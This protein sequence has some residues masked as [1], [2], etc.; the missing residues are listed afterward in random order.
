MEQLSNEYILRIRKK[1]YVLHDVWENCKKY[2]GGTLYPWHNEA[3]EEIE[4]WQSGDEKT[5]YELPFVYI[6]TFKVNKYSFKGGRSFVCI[7]K[8]IDD[9][10]PLGRENGARF[11]EM[12]RNEL[13]GDGKD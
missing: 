1:G 9:A 7:T 11:K 3:F 13:E 6:E 5:K 10:L 8:Q 12:I 2:H 4:L